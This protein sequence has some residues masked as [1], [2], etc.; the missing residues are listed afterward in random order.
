[1][2]GHAKSAS[3]GLTLTTSAT[4]NQAEVHAAKP[5]ASAAGAVA[6]GCVQGCWICYATDHSQAACPA[7][8]GRQNA[9]GKPAQSTACM[10]SRSA[11]RSVADCAITCQQKQSSS[12]VQATINQLLV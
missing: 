8:V 5:E 1:V 4:S 6:S 12:V 10:T 7:N 11:E 9:A 2:H 3:I